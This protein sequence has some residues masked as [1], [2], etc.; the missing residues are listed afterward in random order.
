MAAR[1]PILGQHHVLEA[2]G[3]AVD[4]RH[5][6]VAARHRKAAAGAEI[7]LDVDH[8]QDVAVADVMLFSPWGAPS[9]CASR[10]ST[11]AASRTSASATSTG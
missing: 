10:W 1:V 8:Q 5:D 4:Q 6:L 9:C 11:S 2:R 7:V 3:Q